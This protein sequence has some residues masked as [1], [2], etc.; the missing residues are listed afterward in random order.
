MSTMQSNYAGMTIIE[1]LK[2]TG[3]F[4]TFKRA[5]KKNKVKARQIL[6]SLKLDQKSIERLLS[7]KKW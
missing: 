4:E 7:T 3:Q 2:V 5:L 6:E 1:R